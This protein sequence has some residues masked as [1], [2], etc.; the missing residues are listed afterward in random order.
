MDAA[1]PST[2]TQDDAA[3]RR[4][5]ALTY[6]PTACYDSFHF[7]SC[8][9]CKPKLSL[10]DRVAMLLVYFLKLCGLSWQHSVAR[11]S[12][13]WWKMRPAKEGISCTKMFRIARNKRFMLCCDF[14]SVSSLFTHLQ[15]L[16]QALLFLVSSVPF[17]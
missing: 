1:K 12:P 14:P 8:N 15:L 11:A 2:L 6:P 5:V 7:S 9:I 10:V 16:P 13:V 4:H 17:F 3:R